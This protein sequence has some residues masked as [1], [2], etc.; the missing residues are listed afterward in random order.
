[1]KVSIKSFD[2]QMDVKNN[3]I[4]FEVYDSAGKFLGDCIV[5]K[6]G[7]IWC[8]GKTSRKNGVKVSWQ[9]FIDWMEA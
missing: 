5:T 7:L 3:G 1:M 6:K 9:E 4:E 8:R 2:V